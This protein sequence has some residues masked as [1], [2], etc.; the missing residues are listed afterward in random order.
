MKI[1]FV[2]IKLHLINAIYILKTECPFLLSKHYSM[3]T[4]QLEI[5]NKDFLTLLNY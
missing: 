5:A 3:M 4:T 2:P 1:N